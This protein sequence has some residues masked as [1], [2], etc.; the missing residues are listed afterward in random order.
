MHGLVMDGDDGDVVAEWRRG[1]KMKRL[2][3]HACCRW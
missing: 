3:L 1:E 2:K